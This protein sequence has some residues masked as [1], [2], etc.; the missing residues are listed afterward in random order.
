MKLQKIFEVF[1]ENL[2]Y[3]IRNNGEVYYHLIK[4]VKWQ[5]EAIMAA[6]LDRL[7]DDDIYNII[8]NFVC[9]FAA[10]DEDAEES[11]F[12]DVIYNYEAEPYTGDLTKWLNSNICNVYYLTDAIEEGVENG[13]Q[14]LQLA[15]KKF[16]IEIG[17]ELFNTILEDKD[18]I[19]REILRV[20]QKE[21]TDS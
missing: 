8:Y 19:Q 10:L 18:E 3:S 4:E 15:R 9:E 21:Q 6:H 5:Q 11:D 7:P 13:F 1:F 14:A 20:Q 16:A 2:T 17:T 12:F